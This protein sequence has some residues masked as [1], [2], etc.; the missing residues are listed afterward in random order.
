M[1]YFTEGN[2]GD[3]AVVC[4]P[5]AGFGKWQFIPREPIAG[6][7][8]VAV[9]DIGHGNSSPLKKCPVF[10]ESVEDVEEL[11]NALEIE[12]FYLILSGTGALL[13]T[14]FKKTKRILK[15]RKSLKQK[16]IRKKKTCLILLKLH[17]SHRLYLLTVLHFASV[18][19]CFLFLF[20]PFSFQP[21]F[22]G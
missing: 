21:I 6:I 19:F 11:L 22:S 12:K 5:S 15:R 1:A 17:F 7:Y 14:G 20:R 13:R 10:S 9:D 4:F 16:I 8:L 3:P 2:K 18:V